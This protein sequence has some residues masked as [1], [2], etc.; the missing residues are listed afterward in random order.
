MK[1]AHLIGLS[2]LTLSA[3][4]APDA[5]VSERT[6]AVAGPAER[7]TS[8]RGQSDLICTGADGDPCGGSIGLC[9][10]A[11]LRCHGLPTPAS[12]LIGGSGLCGVGELCD[13][14]T[15]RACGDHEVC[16]GTDVRHFGVCRAFDHGQM[17]GRGYA[18]GGSIGV[19]CVAGL[20]CDVLPG[21][22]RVGRCR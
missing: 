3:C 17:V 13:P 22:G 21:I 11:G 4:V 14:D 18:C 5:A 16:A 19:A 12:G 6:G 9:C 20:R 1:R 15:D 7:S 10:E 2:V 8:P